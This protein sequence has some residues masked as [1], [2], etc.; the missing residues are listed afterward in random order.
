MKP[1]TSL[2]LVCI[3][4]AT[5]VH[6]QTNLWQN[7]GN[8]GIGTTNPG[9][10]LDVVGNIR[11]SGGIVSTASSAGGLFMG[12]GGGLDGSSYQLFA[13][14]ADTSNGLYF[15]APRDGAGNKVDIQFN[16]RGGG[17]PG[18]LIKGGSGNVGIG[19]G[20]PIGKLDV[21]TNAASDNALV[22]SSSRGFAENRNW[23]VSLDQ[24]VEGQ[25]EIAPS[26]TKGG[27]VFT[28]TALAIS[29]AG[30]VGIG[31]IAPGA[32]L[33][34]RGDGS[35][36]P[37]QLSDGTRSF[38]IGPSVGSSQGFNIYDD[39][40]AAVRM[41]ID[42]GG[43]VGIGTTTPSHK[44]TVN[45]TVRAKE[46][47][48][49][50]GW[51]DY[52]FADDYKLASLADVESHIKTT[53]HLPGVPSAQEVAEKGV[54]VGDMQAVLLAKIE[55]LTLHVIAQEKRLNGQ[56]AEI[57]ALKAENARLK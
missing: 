9:A 8:I 21:S 43:N 13:L 37:L 50:T 4:V 15:D 16:W 38:R 18:L 19:T 32:R 20:S 30:N 29:N 48:V 53:K 45:G 46:V 52:V 25:L 56:Q 47:I 17:S 27:N 39:T 7:S 2:V 34:I 36:D 54:S 24:N 33:S 57:V 22:L 11:S 51:S 6:A 31:T 12:Y 49:D 44:L 10:K 1:F 55:E 41:R 14:Y 42:N 35:V 3:C 5:A 26:T 40:A 28:N 23:R